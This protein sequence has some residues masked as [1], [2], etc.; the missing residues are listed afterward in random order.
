MIK[1]IPVGKLVMANKSLLPVMAANNGIEPNM[2]IFGSIDV[3]L[4]DVDR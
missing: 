3:I 1:K 2:A 4:P